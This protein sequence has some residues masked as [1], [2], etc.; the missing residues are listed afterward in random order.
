MTAPIEK[1]LAEA[2]IVLDQDHDE[3]RGLD[4]LGDEWRCTSGG[5]R[6]TRQ[7]V[8]VR[9]VFAVILVPFFDQRG[10]PRQWFGWFGVWVV[11]DE[12]DAGQ[13]RFSVRCAGRGAGGDAGAFP[14]GFRVAG[15]VVSQCASVYRLYERDVQFEGL[16]RL[17]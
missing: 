1:D 9:R 12:P 17:E 11:G 8:I 14:H 2:G 6:R 10:G 7:A 15:R 4:K 5:W 3:R 16:A 13:V